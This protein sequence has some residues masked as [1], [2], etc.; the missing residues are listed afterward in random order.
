VVDPVSE[1]RGAKLHEPPVICATKGCGQRLTVAAVAG[2]S[3]HCSRQHAGYLL[4]SEKPGYK[5][6][7]G[8]DPDAPEPSNAD[9]EEVAPW[10]STPDPSTQETGARPCQP[11]VT[12]AFK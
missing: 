3:K 10:G 9:L 4:P 2:G 11:T 8:A 1:P 12:G 6:G 5:Y 7:S